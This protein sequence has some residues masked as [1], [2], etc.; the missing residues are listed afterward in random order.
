[1]MRLARARCTNTTL[2]KYELLQKY[3]TSAEINLQSQ[4]ICKMLR[5]AVLSV[6]VALTSAVAPLKWPST[7]MTSGFIVL[8]YGDISE[9][10]VAYVDSKKG[11]SRLDT[12]D[13]E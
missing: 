7:Y 4:R 8:P 2:R 13:S 11:M 6:L 9:P 3:S 12:Y 10:F 1:M 5:V